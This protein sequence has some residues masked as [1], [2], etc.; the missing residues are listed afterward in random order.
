VREFHDQL[1]RT[2]ANH[3]ELWYLA[4]DRM[5]DL[6][7]DLEEGDA[8]I[9]SILQ[10]VRQ[11]TEIRKYIGKGRRDRSRGRYV[12]PQEEELADGKRPDLRFH[13]V[14]FDAP[15]PAELK[16]A[17]KWT[18]PHLFERLEVQ[19]C[20]DYLCDIRSSRGIFG[21]VYH[22]TKSSWN[23]PNGSRAESFDA[24]ICPLQNHCTI[25]APQFPGV[26]DIK[27]IGID[28]TKRGVGAKQ[29]LR[30]K[31]PKQDATAPS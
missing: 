16:L 12:I 7:H 21:L 10:P 4:V 5:V 28:L 1:E 2:P 30:S 8:S 15:V 25:L 20:G 17:D 22:G 19:L 14:G 6:K 29:R 18:E 27:V 23:L 11:E 3:R 31:R 26:E 24:L 9:A 13:G